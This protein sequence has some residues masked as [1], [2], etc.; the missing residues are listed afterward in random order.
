MTE[1]TANDPC[2]PQFEAVEAAMA[3]LHEIYRIPY[4]QRDPVDAQRALDDLN[5]R[6]AE[7]AAC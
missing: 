1:Q 7:L 2:A 4:A 3:R 6:G 5:E